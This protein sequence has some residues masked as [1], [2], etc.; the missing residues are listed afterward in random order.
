MHIVRVTSCLTSAATIERDCDYD[1]RIAR[2]LYVTSINGGWISS[3]ILS[4]MIFPV[5]LIYDI[6][7]LYVND[8]TKIFSLHCRFMY[9]VLRSLL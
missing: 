8:S 4:Q 6:S 5:I 3:D 2:D 7:E 9:K 1:G